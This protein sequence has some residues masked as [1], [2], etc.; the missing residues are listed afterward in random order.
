MTDANSARTKVYT[1]GERPDVHV[2]FTQKPS[3][4]LVQIQAKPPRSARD[5]GPVGTRA[6]VCNLDR[7]QRRRRIATTPS[8]GRAPGRPCG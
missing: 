5:P 1:H 2:P 3:S 6:A 7:C 4:S 8:C